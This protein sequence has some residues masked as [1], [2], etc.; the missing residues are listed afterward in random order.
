MKPSTT[1][2]CFALLWIAF[3]PA[4][5]LPVFGKTTPTKESTPRQAES[6]EAKTKETAPK[7]KPPEETWQKYLEA[8]KKYYGDGKPDEA[9]NQL[10][11]ALSMSEQL[12]GSPRADA[13]CH[14]ADLYMSLGLLERAQE[15][16]ETAI[17]IKKRQDGLLLANA[18]DNLANV[19][20]K[21]SKYEEA[22]K[23]QKKA[24]A[25]YL[26]EKD[27]GGRD[28][29]IFLVNCANT[30][31]AQKHFVEAKKLLADALARHTKLAG[32]MSTDVAGV[33]MSLSGL[34]SEQNELDKA[35]RALAYSEKIL[36]Q[37]VSVDHPLRKLCIKNQ[38]VLQKKK[39]DQM[40]KADE[41]LYRPELAKEL[42]VLAEKYKDEN[43]ITH[44]TET[45]KQTLNINEKLLS[46]DDPKFISI[47]ESYAGCLKKL[48]DDAE[49]SKIEEKLR[50]LKGQ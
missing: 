36:Q 44:A 31:K 8:A 14:I 46:P 42:V 49:A 11:M 3:W 19:Y 7:E 15:L 25:I 29:A 21:K 40:L 22:E 39:V 18:M 23:L 37:K 41:N 6:K 35:A 43:D 28:Y 24:S 48:G 27:Q 16:L 47:M 38:C 4:L 17:A 2:S 12:K 26:S 5:S 20:T 30:E 13:F 33:Y 45:Y 32:E 10:D 50:L 34:F 1:F 9:A